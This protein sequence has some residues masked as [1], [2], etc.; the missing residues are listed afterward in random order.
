MNQV[1]KVVHYPDVSDSNVATQFYRE[2]EDIVKAG[3]SIV[4]LDLKNLTSITGSG[5]MALVE[6]FKLIRSAGCKVFICSLN[7]QVRI[8]FELTGLDRVLETFSSLDEFYSS[9]LQKK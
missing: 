8:L 7:D 6:V 4:L 9:M 5:L 1:V 3:A 2:I